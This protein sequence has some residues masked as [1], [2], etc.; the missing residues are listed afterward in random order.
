MEST[1]RGMHLRT[2]ETQGQYDT[3]RS[4]RLRKRASSMFGKSTAA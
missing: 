2:R 1:E 4:P 3:F